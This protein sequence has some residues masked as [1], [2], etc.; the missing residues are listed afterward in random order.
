MA[1]RSSRYRQTSDEADR[2]TDLR[3]RGQLRDAYAL[4]KSYY[5]QGCREDSF[6]Q[7][8]TWVM[9]DC[10][11]RY[12][13]SSTRFFGDI[14]AYCMTL[15]QIRRFPTNPSRDEMFIENLERHVL[16]VGWGLRK[17]NK[18]GDLQVL[19]NEICLWHNGSPLF[20]P[21]VAR[22]LLVSLKQYEQS[23]VV[24]NWL[25]A[26][27][28]PWAAV[29]SGQAP[30]KITN[31]AANDAF[32]WALYDELKRFA[33]D[34]QGNSPDIRSLVYALSVIRALINPPSLRS[35]EAVELAA[36]KLVHVGWKCRELKN[37]K[38]IETLL[39]E[40]I[41]WEPSSTMHCKEVLTMFFVSLK[42]RPMDIISLVEWYGV[43]GLEADA[44]LPREYEGKKLPSLAEEIVRAYLDALMSKD[45]SGNS[46]ASLE[47]KD[48]GCER[49]K[50]LLDQPRCSGWIWEPYKLGKLLCE[51]GRY[52][53]A[54]KWLA[55]IVAANQAEPWA[56][57][58]FG[59]AWERES[60]DKYQKCLFM[61]LS[62]SKKDEY[63][64]ALHEDAA[65]LFASTGEYAEAKTEILLL[66]RLCEE[67]GWRSSAN[68]QELKSSSWYAGAEALESNERLYSALS[69]G[70]T[71]IVA[72]ELPWTE[73]Y[74]DRVVEDKG[75]AHIVIEDPLRGGY[76]RST[77]KG[78][79]IASCVIDGACYRGH[80]GPK[81]RSLIGRIEQ[82]PEAR[83]A[84]AFISTYSGELDLVNN[85]GFVNA[86]YM[87]NVWV[88]PKLLAECSAKQFQ[89]ASGSCRKTYKPPKAPSVEGTWGW[90]ATTIELGAEPDPK[91]YRKEGVGHFEYAR[92]RYGQRDFG[93]VRD[94]RSNEE[95]YVPAS[96]AAEHHLSNY[97][98]IRFI[99]EK[100]WDKKKRRWGWKVTDI[101]DDSEV[102]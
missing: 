6:M 78:S 62:V 88:P 67:N 9:Y 96:L 64:R 85:Y 72:D 42:E 3:K 43:E 91:S 100:S 41:K 28:A 14:R 45:A 30:A 39:S 16:R 94:A 59:K 35:H 73:F 51:V 56:W 58:A 44:F 95:I 46:L 75:L 33:G 2:V 1:Y 84:R 29:Y 13:D 38:Q 76:V 12:Y 54:R 82:L 53:E 4:A 48:V 47:S 7:A 90:E 19:C 60:Q 61:G 63:A 97:K 15:A 31:E 40:A 22:M 89:H 98:E 79:D 11:K 23:S 34:D 17:E 26:A 101:I 32:A 25:G 68:V 21:D 57:Q 5:S 66:D 74:V 83:I 77:V 50:A 93:F 86:G 18:I 70:T 20:T 55:P 24:L 10:L 81:N 65:R 27:N 71:D 37:L 8:Y 92:S 87:K 80:F 36:G 69:A 49:I 99:A 52:E 102:D